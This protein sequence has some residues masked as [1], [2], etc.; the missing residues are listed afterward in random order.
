MSN[1]RKESDLQMF[2]LIDCSNFYASCER[3]FQP[4]LQK[5][6][7]VVLSNND[8]CVI[9]RSDE[10]K[11]LGIEMGVPFFKIRDV[12]AWNNVH[13]ASSNFALYGDMSRRVMD[14]IQSHIQDVEIYSVD[15]AFVEFPKNMTVDQGVE[16]AHDM[17]QKILQ[18]TGIPTRVGIGATK[19]LAK[20]GNALA[21]KNLGGVVYVDSSDPRLFR[22]LPLK[23]IWGFGHQ[24][25]QRLKRYAIHTVGQLLSR[26]REWVRKVL[27]VTGERTYYELKGLVCYPLSETIDEDQKS[28]MVTR[29]FEQEVR[30]IEALKESITRYCNNAGEKLRKRG[31]WAYNIGVYIRSSPFKDGYYSNFASVALN[32]PTQDTRVLIQAAHEALE[33][34]YRPGV[35]Y[36][37]SGIMLGELTNTGDVKQFDLLT[38]HTQ[39]IGQGSERSS[40]T[41]LK[42]I[43]T[44]NQKYGRHT[45]TVGALTKKEKTVISKRKYRSS[46]YTTRWTEILK[47]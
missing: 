4:K 6:P 10:A 8:G 19:T 31:L 12:V 40:E 45:V 29:S 11:E 24:Q 22:D 23:T 34:I 39:N 44:L 46:R 33:K 41:S 20:L 37:K 2:A 15:E 5:Q 27:T 21:K 47:V 35:G 14:I 26:N 25:E 9:A 43:D 3:V 1:N 42:A 13:I 36:K 30:D 16:W 7:I 38:L 28:L 32:Q 18:W 17:R